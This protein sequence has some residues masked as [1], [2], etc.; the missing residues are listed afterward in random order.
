MSKEYLLLE[1]KLQPQIQKVR[2][3]NYEKIIDSLDTNRSIKTQIKEF[4][5][6]KTDLSSDEFKECLRKIL[7]TFGKEGILIIFELIVSG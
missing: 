2:Q 6:K 3:E 5:K 4:F 7:R 1:K